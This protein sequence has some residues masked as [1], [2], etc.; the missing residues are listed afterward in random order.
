MKYSNLISG[1]RSPYSNLIGGIRSP[2]SNLIGREKAAWRHHRQ[3]FSLS[4]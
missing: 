1:I 3:V 2:Y 4:E